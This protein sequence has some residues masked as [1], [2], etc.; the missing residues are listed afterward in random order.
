MGLGW[1]RSRKAI[2]RRVSHITVKQIQWKFRFIGD[3]LLY[4]HIAIDTGTCHGK[5]VLMTFINSGS[6]HF[7]TF[8]EML[9]GRR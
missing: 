6:V 3:I 7:L 4:Y 2:F 1:K 8:I 9:I 5:T